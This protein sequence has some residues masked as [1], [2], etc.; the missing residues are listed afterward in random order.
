[1]EEDILQNFRLTYLAETEVN[2]C[3]GLG[4]VLANDEIINGVSE[5]GGHPVTK[6]K[7]KQWIMR[8]G[9]YAER[10]LEGLD[11]VDWPEP[12]KEMQRNW[13]GKS[14]GATVF[15]PL[16]K[17][18]EA[19][20]VFTTRPDTIFG[21]TFMT[22]APELELVKIITTP[23]HQ[24][25]VEAYIKKSAQRSERDRMADVK[26]ISGVFTGA[27]ALHPLTQERVPIW[28]GD[29]VLAGYGTGAV[30]AVPCGDQRDYDFAQHFDIPIKN[31]FANTDG[32][33]SDDFYHSLAGMQRYL[34]GAMALMAPYVNSYRRRTGTG[35]CPRP[36]LDR[37][38]GA[39]FLAACCTAG[40]RHA[41]NRPGGAVAASL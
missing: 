9:V 10:L 38:Y 25:A 2:W 36:Q 4:T 41:A 14:T 29:Y 30:M 27:Y 15:F 32:T 37:R 17:H 7:M 35:V 34:S 28:I 21:V 12:L 20:E 18:P 40:R 16:E 33:E 6:K 19:I 39:A 31:I 3:P 5:R 26:T 22:L 11:R 1:M 13:I 23:E 24:Q 8:I